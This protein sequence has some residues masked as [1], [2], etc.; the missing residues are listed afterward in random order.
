MANVLKKDVNSRMTC[1]LFVPSEEE[2]DAKYQAIQQYEL[3]V[4][5]LKEEDVPHVNFCIWV[6]PATEV[7]T[8][9]PISSRVQLST[10]R[11]LKKKN[12]NM[13]I[14]RR[15]MNENDKREIDE[16][17]AEV[18]V[19]IEERLQKESMNGS[20]IGLQQSNSVDQNEKTMQ[21]DKSDGDDDDSGSDDDGFPGNATKTIVAEG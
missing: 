2:T 18:D 11:P 16:R 10:G 12:Y 4:L 6:D 7:A 8:Y 14:T 17:L 3:D 1:Q 15:P 19:D 5:P 21:V 20:N 9:L 13:N